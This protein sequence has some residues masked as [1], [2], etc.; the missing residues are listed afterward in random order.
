MDYPF[1]HFFNYVVIIVELESGKILTDATEPLLTFDRLPPFCFNDNGLII[2]EAGVGWVGLESP[3][4]SLNNYTIS[5]KPD[6]D[7]LKSTILVSSQMTEFEGLKM[8]KNYGT[9]DELLTK[10]LEKGEY[11]D[12]SQSLLPGKKSE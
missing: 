7:S 6:P 8:H 1:S 3:K 2:D 4:A 10:S 12:R 5:Q 11:L 9:D